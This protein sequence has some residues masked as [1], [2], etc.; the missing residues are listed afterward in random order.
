MQIYI[1]FFAVV[2]AI[3]LE[4]GRFF[5]QVYASRS[6]RN[7]SRNPFGAGTVFQFFFF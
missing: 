2:V 6:A 5:N 3:P 4:Q 7:A 1:T